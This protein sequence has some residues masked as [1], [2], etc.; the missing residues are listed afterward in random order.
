M[1]T[2][3]NEPNWPG[4]VAV[5]V[6]GADD[7]LWVCD[8]WPDKSAHW[9]PLGGYITSG[10]YAIADTAGNIHTFVKGA[11]VPPGRTSS[12][13]GTRREPSGTVREEL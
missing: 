3:V 10:G 4:Y 5:M 7:S 12:R 6:R 1:P 9:V 13:A 8:L 11:T 2:A